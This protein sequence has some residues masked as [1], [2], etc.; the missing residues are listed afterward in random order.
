MRWCLFLN[1]VLN[2][3]GFVVSQYEHR[4]YVLKHSSKVGVR[5]VHIN[6]RVVTVSCDVS[7]SDLGKSLKVILKI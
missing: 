1:N 5:W 4:L 3:P 7:L 2:K 6:E